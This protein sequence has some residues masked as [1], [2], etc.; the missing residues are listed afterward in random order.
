MTTQITTH[1]Q[2]ALD[3][4]I[5]QY[6]GQPRFEGFLTAIVEQIQ[7][8]ENSSIDTINSVI[9]IDEASGSQLDTLGT[10]VGTERGSLTDSEFRNL[11]YIQIGKNTSQ[12]GPEKLIDIFNLLVT[13]AWVKYTNLGNGDVVLAGTAEIPTQDL[14]NSIIMNLEEVIAGGCRISHIVF[15]DE[16]ES[17]AY[18]DNNPNVLAS[19]YADDGGTING[20][21]SEMYRIEFP[22][23]YAEDTFVDINTLGY[24]PGVDDPLVGG[25]YDS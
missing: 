4:L 25:V 3:R 20:I 11:I 13:T 23:A 8:L 14:V 17:F 2:D 9:N 24:G 7:L 12:G 22:F 18:D 16:S 5:T 21:Y 1:V 6:K 10:I 15:S 19:G